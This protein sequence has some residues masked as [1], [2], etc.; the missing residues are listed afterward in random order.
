MSKSTVVDFVVSV[1][2]D[3]SHL[4]DNGNVNRVNSLM[5][6][7]KGH[8]VNNLE[9]EFK[10]TWNGEQAELTMTTISLEELLES[11]DSVKAFCDGWV[12]A[13]GDKIWL[14]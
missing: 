3:Q 8:Y 9:L 6:A 5:D 12:N 13:M 1:Y 2:I 10:S 4:Q 7:V 14:S 11:V